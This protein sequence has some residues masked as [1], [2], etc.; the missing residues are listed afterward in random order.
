[1]SEPRPIANDA[2]S[3]S[4]NPTDMQ[5]DISELLLID[6]WR[7]IELVGSVRERTGPVGQPG[8]L[9]RIIN[10]E[11][12]LTAAISELMQSQARYKR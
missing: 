12:S 10:A 1:V 3:P 4:E 9:L 8:F 7:A 5:A 6:L 11:L 2:I